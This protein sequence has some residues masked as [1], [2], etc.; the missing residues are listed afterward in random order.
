MYFLH[1]VDHGAKSGRPLFSD[2]DR[3]GFTSVQTYQLGELLTYSEKTLRLLNNHLAALKAAG[4]SLAREVTANGICS[5]GFSSLEEAEA[6]LAA[7]QN[8]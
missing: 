1:D 7:K 2:A 8:R 5:Y 3:Y 6:Y 4:R